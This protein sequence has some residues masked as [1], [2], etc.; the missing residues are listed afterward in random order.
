MKKRA[1]YWAILVWLVGCATGQ[2]EGGFNKELAVGYASVTQ[3]RDRAF[4][5]LGEKKIT[6]AEAREVQEEADQAKA[7]LD[8]ARAM[9]PV[10][11]AAAEMRLNSALK[12]IKAYGDKLKAK[13]RP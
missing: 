6:K 7:E 5:L 2:Q 4:V 11:P 12:K 1:L 13:E 9:H 10:E 3:L 8:H